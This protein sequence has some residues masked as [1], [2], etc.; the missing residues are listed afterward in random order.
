MTAIA[1]TA[2]YA[3]LSE[4]CHRIARDDR[5]GAEESW[6]KDFQST[7]SIQPERSKTT[8]GLSSQ[9]RRIRCRLANCSGPAQLVIER[10]SIALLEVFDDRPTV[11]NPFSAVLDKWQLAARCAKRCRRNGD[12]RN[13]DQPLMRLRLEAERAG[14]DRPRSR[15]DVETDHWEPS[16]NAVTITPRTSGCNSVRQAVIRAVRSASAKHL[17]SKQPIRCGFGRDRATIARSAS[18]RTMSR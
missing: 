1:L 11:R 17:R 7:G 3:A 12:E 5:H 2:Q 13:A 18:V 15:E 6:P 8:Y 10:I 14:I 4:G 9:V 16:D